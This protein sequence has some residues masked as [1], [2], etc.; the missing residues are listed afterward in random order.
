MAEAMVFVIDDEFEN[1]AFMEEII[2]S[3]GYG[4]ETF[5]DGNE[6]LEKMKVS[7]PGMIFLDVQMPIINGFQV[8]KAVREIKGLEDV[9]VVLLSAISSVTGRD[10]DPD[11]IE[12]RY[13]VRPSAF[14]P[15]PISPVDTTHRLSGEKAPDG[16]R[17][18]F[19]DRPKE[20]AFSGHTS[21]QVRQTMHSE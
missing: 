3:A 16:T 14:V 11:T 1:L 13:G 21:S 7:A 9:P 17:A 15:K 2:G 18:P 8:L 4:V 20:T 10:H 12:A 19:L 6:A 5:T